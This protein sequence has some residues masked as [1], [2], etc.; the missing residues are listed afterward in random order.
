LI[1]KDFSKFV[2]DWREL[3][4]VSTPWGIELNK[5]ILGLILDDFIE[6]LSYF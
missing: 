3:L 1:F 2:P 6:V 4:A 5:Y